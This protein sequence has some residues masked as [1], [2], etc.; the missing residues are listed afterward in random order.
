M[1]YSVMSI[2]TTTMRFSQY[3]CLSGIVVLVCAVVQLCSCA[4]GEQSLPHPEPLA[5]LIT[6]ET[7]EN[8]FPPNQGRLVDSIPSPSPLINL[9]SF[10]LVILIML[11]LTFLTERDVC[12]SLW[13]VK[14]LIARVCSCVGLGACRICTQSRDSIAFSG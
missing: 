4:V 7:S 3:D 5:S 12:W 1:C 2:T 13:S 11:G 9:A 6:S 10:N 8:F 14:N